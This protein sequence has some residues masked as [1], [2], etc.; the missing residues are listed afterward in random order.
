MDL[1][2]IECAWQD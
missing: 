2:I 1:K